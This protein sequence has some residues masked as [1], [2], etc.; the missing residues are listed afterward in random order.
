V[1]R[2]CKLS[3]PTP[4]PPYRGRLWAMR[5]SICFSACSFVC[6]HHRRLTL[7]RQ[8]ALLLSTMKQSQIAIEAWLIGVI[9]YS[10]IQ[11]SSRKAW[12]SHYFDVVIGQHDLLRVS[13]VII[14]SLSVMVVVMT[15][16]FWRCGHEVS[17]AQCVHRQWR[18]VLND[19]RFLT[20]HITSVYDDSYRPYTLRMEKFCKMTLIT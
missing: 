4:R 12:L 6:R 9:H 17:L 20:R 13:A 15:T 7:I 5:M 2:V 16:R 3:S 14:S 11:P 8:R 19:D 18:Q 10:S 1:Q